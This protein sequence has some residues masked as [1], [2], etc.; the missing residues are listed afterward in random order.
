MRVAKCL[1]CVAI[2]VLMV[3]SSRAGGAP[4]TIFADNF[5]THANGA[6]INSVS[7]PIGSA[8]NY[9]IATGSGSLNVIQNAVNN[10]GNAL[11]ATRTDGGAPSN[12]NGFWSSPEGL[13]QGPFV[14]TITYDLFRAN[15]ESNVGVG[16]DIGF[17]F[18]SFNPTLLHGTGSGNNLLYRNSATN[19][20]LN[21]GFVTGHGGWE[22]YEIVLT[23]S[24]PDGND[25]IFGTYDVYLARNDPNNSEG[26]LAKTLIVDDAPAY[27]NGVTNNVG[28]GRFTYF[29]GAPVPASGND[30]VLYFDNVSVV[31]SE[32]PEPASF[33]LL[34]AGG[35]AVLLRS[36]R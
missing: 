16:I 33:T 25:K 24:A 17:G 11:E 20:Y 1:T 6:Q 30:S 22:T 21:S 26:L 31:R 5:D 13:L 18:G 34:L 27:S 15:S 3:L 32:I 4:L 19:S 29:T 9:Q 23:T 12:V 8:S 2:A 35:L 7:P 10:G 14:Y 36:R 28:I